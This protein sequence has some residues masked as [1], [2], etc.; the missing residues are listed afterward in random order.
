MRTKTVDKRLR[1]RR[2]KH[3]SIIQIV[4]V[5]YT[6]GSARVV[7]FGQRRFHETHKIR[8]RGGRLRQHSV[9]EQLPSNVEAKAVHIRFVNPS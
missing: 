5:L 8:A 1:K 9:F 4:S 3:T 6:E 7:F 2:E